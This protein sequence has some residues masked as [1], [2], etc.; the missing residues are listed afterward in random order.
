MDEPTERDILRW[1]TALRI[2]RD[3]GYALVNGRATPLAF[4][5]WAWQMILAS[6]GD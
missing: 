6:L 4:D 3:P 5:Y 1:M 2:R